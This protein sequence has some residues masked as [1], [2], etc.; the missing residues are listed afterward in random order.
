MASARVCGSIADAGRGA[1]AIADVMPFACR[2]ALSRGDSGGGGVGATG[3]AGRGRGAGR[4]GAAG[5]AGAGLPSGGSASSVISRVNSAPQR[6]VST[7][8][9]TGSLTRAGLL[10]ST[11]ARSSSPAGTARMRSGRISRPVS[12]S[13]TS[14][15]RQ[16]GCTRC[17]GHSKARTRS[18]AAKGCPT[19]AWLAD[20]STDWAA[21]GIVDAAAIAP[22]RAGA[23][24][25]RPRHARPI[26][27]GRRSLPR[28]LL[29]PSCSV[30]P[31][32]AR[33]VRVR[34]WGTV[35]ARACGRPSRAGGPSQEG[36]VTPSGE[37]TGR[38]RSGK[39]PRTKPAAGSGPGAGGKEDGGRVGPRP[40]SGA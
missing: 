24:R 25:I 8:R 6:T 40:L 29:M 22:S 39:A 17:A 10:S 38:W 2:A 36:R 26:P 23:T 18:V 34:T 20:A 37:G 1:A 9:S 15:S 30:P 27:V 11:S 28:S 21:V 33:H 14:A 12:G 3:L 31:A 7:T 5:A 13:V 16:S 35:G 4:S 32:G 19:R